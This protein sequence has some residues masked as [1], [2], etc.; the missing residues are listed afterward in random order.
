MVTHNAR[1]QGAIA[2]AK[3]PTSLMG[4]TVATSRAPSTTTPPSIRPDS[5]TAWATGLHG[6]TIDEKWSG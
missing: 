2:Y 5:M 4:K 3:E 1:T 6:S